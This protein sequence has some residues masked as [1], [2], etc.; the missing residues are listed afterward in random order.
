VPDDVAG[1]AAAA[2]AILVF[3]ARRDLLHHNLGLVCGVFASIANPFE[4]APARADPDQQISQIVLVHQ[5]ALDVR[6]A[7]SRP[8]V[9]MNAVRQAVNEL[10]ASA[11]SMYTSATK[12]DYRETPV[13]SLAELDDQLV[14]DASSLREDVETLRDSHAEVAERWTE[15]R[16]LEAKA[17]DVFSEYV[18]LVRGV[19]LRSNGAYSEVCRI[20]DDLVN[21]VASGWRSLTI[22]ARTERMRKSSGYLIRI[23][24]PEWTIW[25]L[26]LAVHEYGH[27]YLADRQ[28]DV[29]PLDSMSERDA[30]IFAAD[31]FAALTAGPAYA[32]ALFTS[33]LDPGDDGSLTGRRAAIVLGALEEAAG[34]GEA[35]DFVDLLHTTWTSIA[36]DCATGVHAPNDDDQRLIKAVKD[37]SARKRFSFGSWLKVVDPIARRLAGQPVGD[38]EFPNVFEAREVLNAAWL[39]RLGMSADPNEVELAA[40]PLALAASNTAGAAEDRGS[41]SQTQ[42]RDKP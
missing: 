22:P 36:T 34:T 9:D 12:L 33:R 21:E 38:D 24:F 7:V 31:A 13:R 30:Q 42:N 6:N 35:M 4:V 32:C 5:H 16:R 1:A 25:T 20:A 37:R 28:L 8:N 2:T 26:P 14:Q 39:A 11:S 40:R 41:A 23:G 17:N 29:L 15:L 27:V 3:D 18:D 19:A 10:M